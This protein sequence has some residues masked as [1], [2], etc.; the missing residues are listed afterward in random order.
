M[1]INEGH[2]G[3]RV[4]LWKAL[5][6]LPLQEPGHQDGA[7]GIAAVAP[8]CNLEGCTVSG[9]LQI[10]RRGSKQ[11]LRIQLKRI[12]IQKHWV[13]LTDNGGRVLCVVC[14]D[15]SL[16]EKLLVQLD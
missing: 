1:L 5:I 15:A 10:A 2:Q 14:V 13:L 9:V 12:S 11:A 4:L 8:T 3:M 7:T 6:W 16:C